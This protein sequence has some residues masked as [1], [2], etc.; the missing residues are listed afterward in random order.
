MTKIKTNYKKYEL[1]LY[2][3]VIS[4]NRLHQYYLSYQII[5]EKPKVQL[6]HKSTTIGIDLNIKKGFVLSNGKIYYRPDK[7]RLINRIK[8]LQSKCSRDK[9]RIENLEKANPDKIITPSKRS[10]KRKISVQKKY[11][12]LA[13]IEENF[14]QTTTADIIKKYYPK[15]IVMENLPIE[16]EWKKKVY[17]AKQVQN[18]AFYRC[19][20]VMR[21]K[22]ER[23]NISFKLAAKDY[24]SS[25]ICSNCGHKRDI[26]GYPFYICP[27][28]GMKL[29]RDINAAIN[30]S[31]L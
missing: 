17:I 4:R 26:H 19:R 25:Q 8:D 10:L 9:K 31:K 12:H 14:I 22:A 20:E 16:K 15:K 7:S 24:A 29:D 2:N 28:C 23:Y 13:N 6:L 18:A 21:Y 11:Q 1:K 27:V 30:L 5:R 3:V